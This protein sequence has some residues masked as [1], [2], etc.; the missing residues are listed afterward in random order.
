MP[1]KMLTTCSIWNIY[2]YFLFISCGWTRIDL[3]CILMSCIYSH[4]LFVRFLAK[5]DQKPFLISV[6]SM[7]S[8][9]HN[10]VD[11]TRQISIKNSMVKT[12]WIL[13]PNLFCLLC[14]MLENRLLRRNFGP[15]RDKLTGGS[16]KLHNE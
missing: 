6:T 2:A 7:R 13:S 16:R 5:M 12:D 9:V 8:S 3:V 4:P 10:K 1:N 14:T 15:K 11:A